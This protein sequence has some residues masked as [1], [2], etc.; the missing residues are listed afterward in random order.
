MR[1][2]V[3]WNSR[4]SEV[5]HRFGQPCPE[6]YARYAV[7]RVV[8]GLRSGGHTVEL[9]E[10]D[11]RLLER[12]REFASPAAD[13][14]T[15]MAHSQRHVP[16]PSDGMV[17]NMAYGI[18]GESRYTH[19]P[20]MLEMAGVPYT[21][22]APLGHALAL[23]KVLTKVLI[24][25]A[26]VPTPK[27]MVADRPDREPSGLRFPLVV[28]PRH[29]STSFGLQT[30]YDASKLRDAVSSVL[31]QYNQ[32]ALV[33]EFVAGREVCVGLLGNQPVECLPLV[34]LDFGPRATQAF[35]WED[36]MHRRPD[37]PRKRC[38][39]AVPDRLAAELREIAVTTFRACHCRDYARVD[40][41]IDPSGTPYVLE[42]NSMA[43]L[44]NSASYVLAAAAGYGFPELVCRILDVA[45]QRY[46]GG[47]APRDSLELPQR[48]N[49]IPSGIGAT[50]QSPPPE[51][52]GQ[53][54]PVA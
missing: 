1:V 42:I 53:E 36:K 49:S 50:S 28:K 46:F 20:A 16:G 40:V 47:P 21:G 41:R 15:P 32:E 54:Q 8:E 23:D 19:V 51:S 10:G 34:E 37:E 9:L 4:L 13:A 24:R 14:G 43:S 2:A 38:P 6:A 39:A 11:A 3:V 45:Y 22:S 5:I 30:V 33:E 17:F 48:P 25:E 29:E 26:G 7:E 35:T 18:Q 31:T 27:W 52:V 12:L 44:G